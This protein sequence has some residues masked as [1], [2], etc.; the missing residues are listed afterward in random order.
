MEP[1][2]FYL[3]FAFAFALPQFTGVKCKRKRKCK[4]NKMKFFSISCVG[5]CACVCIC[6][7]VVHT[8]IFLRLHLH[9]RHIC[10]PGLRCMTVSMT[11]HSTIMPITRYPSC[12][13]YKLIHY[14]NLCTW[15]NT[16]KVGHLNWTCS[17]LKMPVGLNYYCQ[18]LLI[19][20]SISSYE[21]LGLE[22]LPAP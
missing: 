18:N 8:C 10:E 21:V 22:S 14:N 16:G 20:T 3:V 1:V 12:Y 6:V 19:Q 13:I 11:T 15:F 2:L 17:I 4:C 9:L 7:T 5:S